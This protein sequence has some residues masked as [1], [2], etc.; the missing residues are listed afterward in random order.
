MRHVQSNNSLAMSNKLQCNGTIRV[1]CIALALAQAQSRLTSELHYVNKLWPSLP[2]CV[3]L[4]SPGDAQD[5]QFDS[6]LHLSESFPA[7]NLTL[8][9]ICQGVRGGEPDVTHRISW[10]ESTGECSW[11]H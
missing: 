4:V 7:L 5:S 11:Q 1:R 6:V 10:H 2:P 3:F 8:F 9:C